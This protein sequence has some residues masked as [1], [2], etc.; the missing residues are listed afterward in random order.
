VLFGCG[1]EFREVVP[2][3]FVCEQAES[4]DEFGVVGAELVGGTGEQVCVVDGVL[5]Q[6]GE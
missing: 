4:V 3:G 2:V 5:G 1:Q 6:L